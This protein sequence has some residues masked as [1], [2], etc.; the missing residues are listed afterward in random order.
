MKSFSIIKISLSMLMLTIQFGNLR[1]FAAQQS[2]ISAIATLPATQPEIFAVIL[3]SVKTG[4]A[5]YVAQ[6]VE[7]SKKR[8]QQLATMQNKS[9]NKTSMANVNEIDRTALDKRRLFVFFAYGGLYLGWFQNFLY[10]QIYTKLFPAA[11]VF[12]RESIRQ[13]LQDPAGASAVLKQVI[14][15]ATVHWPWL[16]VPAFYVLQQIANPAGF[17]MNGLVDKLRTNWR[18]DLL[19]CWKVWIPSAVINF[20]CIPA[21]YQVFFTAFVSLAYTTMFSLRRGGEMAKEQADGV[22]PKAALKASS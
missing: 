4:G 9:N 20:S 2:I 10:S 21:Q 18:D 13:K 17:S 15:E 14:V 19:V 3:T 16:Y 7:A 22:V 6:R 1:A 12:A 8:N 5:D 11:Q